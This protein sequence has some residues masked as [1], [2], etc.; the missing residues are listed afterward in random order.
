MKTSKKT[1]EKFGIP[2]KQHKSVVTELIRNMKVGD[3]KK[4]PAD[5]T[6]A[7]FY[8]AAGTCG[9]EIVTRKID[10]ELFIWRIK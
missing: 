1:L 9:Y 6:R 5:F 4:A 8:H 3:K 10:D 2:P 7:S